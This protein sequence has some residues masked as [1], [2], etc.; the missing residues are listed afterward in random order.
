MLLTAGTHHIRKAEF[1]WGGFL[2]LSQGVNSLGALKLIRVDRGQVAYY[3]KRGELEILEP[4]M[5]VIAPPDRFGGFLSTQLQLMDL[6][7]QVHESAD[8]VQL[9]IDAVKIE[10][11]D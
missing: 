5:H 1:K 7:K 11:S 10:I 3:Y 8:Y 2:D 9:S 4:G 6:P